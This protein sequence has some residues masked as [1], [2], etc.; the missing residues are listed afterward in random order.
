MKKNNKKVEAC[1]PA[2]KTIRQTVLFCGLF[3]VHI[4]TGKKKTMN[5]VFTTTEPGIIGVNY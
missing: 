5:Q 4:A 2:Y 3:P 1:P